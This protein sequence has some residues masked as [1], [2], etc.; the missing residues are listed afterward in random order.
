MSIEEMGSL[1]VA[2]RI[3]LSECGD[4]EFSVPS[5]TEAREFAISGGVSRAV[6]AAA[7]VSTAITPYCVDGLD[8]KAIALLKSYAIKGECTQGNLIEVMACQGGCVGGS[9]ILN[10]PKSAEAKVKAMRRKDSQ[11]AGSLK[12]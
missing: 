9:S 5:S 6:S 3:E 1:F 4:Y 11:S 12:K 2:R 10:A 7:P 8:K